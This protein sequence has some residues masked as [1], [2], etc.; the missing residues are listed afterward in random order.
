MD[1]EI[2]LQWAV[3]FQVW[4]LMKMSLIL[5]G[6]GSSQYLRDSFILFGLLVEIGCFLTTF[7]F[8][9]FMMKVVLCAVIRRR[10]HYMV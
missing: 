3:H 5:D 6:C 8:V 10:I 7:G 2:Y 1:L 9:G 4:I